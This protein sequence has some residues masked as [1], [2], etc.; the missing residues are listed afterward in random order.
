MLPHILLGKFFFNFLKSLTFICCAPQDKKELAYYLDAIFET[1]VVSREA[2]PGHDTAE[3]D[4]AGM[5]RSNGRIAF[6]SSPTE[7]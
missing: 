6:T 5:Q 4:A 7:F 1:L 3:E 2:T